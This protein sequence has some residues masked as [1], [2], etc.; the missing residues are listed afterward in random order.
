LVEVLT[1]QRRRSG[2][3]WRKIDAYVVRIFEAFGAIELDVWLASDGPTSP[4]AGSL[5][6]SILTVMRSRGKTVHRA[7][8]EVCTVRWYVRYIEIL[9]KRIEESGRSA[10][11]REETNPKGRT[12]HLYRDP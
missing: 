12:Q 10:V 1:E 4:R 3:V 9:S 11:R 6:A 8:N 7:H 2:L 5:T